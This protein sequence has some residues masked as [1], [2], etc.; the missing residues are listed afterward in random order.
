MTTGYCVKCRTE[1]NK[2]YHSDGWKPKFPI[3]KVMKDILIKIPRYG[4]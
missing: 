4:S 2:E 1:I 3:E